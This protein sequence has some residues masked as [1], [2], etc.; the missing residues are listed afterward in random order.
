MMLSSPAEDSTEGT[1][2]GKAT[3]WLIIDDNNVDRFGH[4]GETVIPG[5]G[6]RWSFLHRE[7]D[8]P[9]NPNFD[10]GLHNEIEGHW[11]KNTEPQCVR[12]LSNCGV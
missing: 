1:V 2:G 5:A 9:L 12:L 11:N 10:P 6:T 4:E 7:L 3:E 8:D